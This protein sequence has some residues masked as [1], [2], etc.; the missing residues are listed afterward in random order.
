MQLFNKTYFQIVK[1]FVWISPREHIPMANILQAN[2]FLQQE[3]V[4]LIRIGCAQFIYAKQFPKDDH[5]PLLSLVVSSIYY[6]NKF[7]RVEIV[8]LMGI[9]FCVFANNSCFQM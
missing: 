8:F 1:L 4:A 3:F 9:I 2:L 6:A 5:F 7:Y